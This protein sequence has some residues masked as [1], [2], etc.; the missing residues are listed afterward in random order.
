MILGDF[1]EDRFVEN[2]RN[3]VPRFFKE[4]RGSTNGV[5][6]KDE[7]WVIC[8]MVSYEDRRNYYHI[9][10][11]LDKETSHV[12]R[13]TTFFTFEGAKVEYTLGFV[14]LENTDEVLIGYSLYDKCAKYM[15][16]GRT[17]IEN[18][19]VEK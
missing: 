4:L 7:V 12:K 16:M 2:Q 3:P 18:M 10:I 11:V 6:I 13:Y 9:V 15:L 8:H 14:Y 5:V 19:M 1:K 17:T